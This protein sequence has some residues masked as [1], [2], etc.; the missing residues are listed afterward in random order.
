MKTLSLEKSLYISVLACLFVIIN[1][2]V[3]MK[4]LLKSYN[5]IMIF[6]VIVVLITLGT[7]STI[8]EK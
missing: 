8:S 1:V 4:K 7:L 3:G 2:F 5:I 6:V